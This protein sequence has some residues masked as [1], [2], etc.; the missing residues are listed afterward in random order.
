MSE[1]LKLKSSHSAPAEPAV[2]WVLKTRHGELDLRYRTALMGVLNIT[3]DSFS[4][5]GKFFDVDK[6]VAHGIERAAEGADIIDIGGESTRPGAQPVT[7]VEET[8]RV[9]PV[10]RGL[11]KRLSILISIDTSKAEVAARA[12]EEGADIVNDISAMRQDAEMASVV[13]AEKVPLI[14]MHMQGTPRTMQV[15]P[16]YIDVVGEVAEFLR[17]RAQVAIAAGIDPAAIVVDPGIGFGK[18][19]EHNLALLRNIPVLAALGFPVIV[20]VSRKAFIGKILDAGPEDRLEG[21]LAAAAVAV[22]GGARIIRVHD[23]RPTAR[24]IRVL[25][26][27]RALP[28]TDQGNYV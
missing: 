12:L 6:A 20:G 19:F 5:G 15:N 2:G 14:L 24:F 27:I 7:A 8:R 3:P 18:G 22:L 4:D 1:L 23:V 26:T 9:A 21:S 13:A 28:G 25:E 17:A 11:R 16:S 10:I